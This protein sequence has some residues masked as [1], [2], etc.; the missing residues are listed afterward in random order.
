MVGELIDWLH[1][2]DDHALHK[3]ARVLDLSLPIHLF[4]LGRFPC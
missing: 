3:H 1:E 2:N 4:E